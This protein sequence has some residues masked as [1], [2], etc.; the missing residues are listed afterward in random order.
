MNA[1]DEAEREEINRELKQLYASLSDEEQKVFN[2]E[3]KVFLVSEYGNISNSYE[4]VKD[5]GSET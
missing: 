5:V 3:L 4:S 1:K 2:E